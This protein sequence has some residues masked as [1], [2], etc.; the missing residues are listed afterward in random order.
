MP[1]QLSTWF[2]FFPFFPLHRLFFFIYSSFPLLSPP[3]ISL[4]AL[5][6]YSSLRLPSFAPFIH[7]HVHRSWSDNAY[8]FYPHYPHHAMILFT[9]TTNPSNLCHLPLAGFLHIPFL[10]YLIT[11]HSHQSML[12]ASFNQIPI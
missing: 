2:F 10:A 5:S 7:S 12:F 4:S 3:S 6:L 1:L 8:I 9:L 11:V